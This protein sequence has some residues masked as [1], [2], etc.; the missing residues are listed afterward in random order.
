MTR[1]SDGLCGALDCPRCHPELQAE[2]PCCVCD[3][4]VPLY[5]MTDRNCDN[6]GGEVCEGCA[7]E[8]IN[9]ETGVYCPECWKELTNG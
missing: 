2:V 1:C 7:D 8:L 3:G 9:D 6:C 5:R 4:Y